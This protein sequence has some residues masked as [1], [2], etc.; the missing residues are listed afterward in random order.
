MTE[1]LG[2]RKRPCCKGGGWRC[3]M[4]AV[5]RVGLSKGG[6]WESATGGGRGEAGRGGSAGGGW[7]SW[8][9]GGCADRDMAVIWTCRDQRNDVSAVACTPTVPGTP[10]PSPLSPYLVLFLAAALLLLGGR[11]AL[12]GG[13]AQALLFSLPLLQHLLQVEPPAVADEEGF[14]LRH[15]LIADHL[16]NGL[17]VFAVF[18]DGWRWGEEKSQGWTGQPAWRHVAHVPTSRAWLPRLSC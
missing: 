12:G 13:R 6:G 17:E 16:G 8:V 4:G 7:G 5:G 14:H 18:P 3:S 10:K 2:W 1:S 15:R 9:G 11:A